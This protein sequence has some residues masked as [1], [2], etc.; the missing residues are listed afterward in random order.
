MTIRKI[1]LSSWATDIT[2]A[3]DLTEWLEGL[4]ARQMTVHLGDRDLPE[5]VGKSVK[6][7]RDEVV[8]EVAK[9]TLKPNGDV[10]INVKFLPGGEEALIA[11]MRDPLAVEEAE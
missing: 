9:A 1:D 7:D 8:G 10:E 11:A 4:P 5:H 3:P 6:N 2:P